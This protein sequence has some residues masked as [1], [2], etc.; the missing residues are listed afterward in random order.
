M[1]LLFMGLFL[2]QVHCFLK[3]WETDMQID[4]FFT[5]IRCKTPSFSFVFVGYNLSFLTLCQKS[6]L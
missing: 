6:F 5:V 1:F 4:V 3:M 2:F